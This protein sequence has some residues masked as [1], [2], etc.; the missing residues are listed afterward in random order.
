MKYFAFFL[1][2]LFSISVSLRWLQ[3]LKEPV[4]VSK[5]T[6]RILTKMETHRLS[7]GDRPA[8]DGITI[9]GSSGTPTITALAGAAVGGAIGGVAGAFLG[10]FLGGLIGVIIW[11]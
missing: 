8:G 4:N 10:L 9:S 11:P 1:V 3:E 2:A 7:G 6:A 5:T